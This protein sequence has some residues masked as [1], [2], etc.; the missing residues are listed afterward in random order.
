[1]E[2]SELYD[3]DDEGLFTLLASKDNELCRRS[4][5]LREGSLF[6]RAVEIDNQMSSYYRVVEAVNTPEKAAAAAEKL[7]GAVSLDCGISI[8]PEE[9]IIDLP[10]VADFETDLFV[11]RSKGVSKPFCQSTSLFGRRMLRA[12]SD[13]LRRIRI[14][15]DRKDCD[16][17]LKSAIRMAAGRV[18]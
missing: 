5:H 6:V 14:F 16:V 1:L 2:Y 3:L 18:L 12:V 10:D 11:T 8:R 13:T 15:V 9:I 4:A 17:R 7:A